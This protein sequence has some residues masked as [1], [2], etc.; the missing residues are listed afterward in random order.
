MDTLHKVNEARPIARCIASQIR[1]PLFCTLILAAFT[2]QAQQPDAMDAAAEEADSAFMEE[3]IVTGLRRTLESAQ[4]IKFQS[5]TIVDSIVADDIANLPDRSVTETLQRIPGVTIDRFISRGDP[6]HFGGEGS[7][8]AVRGLTQVRGEING[9][10]GFTANGGR[11]LSFED[12]PPELL[13]G[14]DVYKNATADMIEGGLG[15]TV[16]L[17]TRMPLDIDGRLFA[18]TATANN[19]NFIEET[20]PSFSAMYSNRWDT[21]AGEFGFLVDLAYSELKGRIDVLFSRPYFPRSDSIGSGD[22]GIPGTTGTVW[23]PRG[24]DWRTERTDRERQGVY[25]AF[26]WR[27]NNGM[28]YYA[29]VFR[30]EYDFTWD[31]DALFVDNDPYGIFPTSSPAGADSGDWAFDGAS[32][33]QS[34]TLSGWRFDDTNGDGVN[35]TWNEIGIPMGSDVRISNRNS[36]TTDFSQGF[37]WNINDNWRFTTDLQYVKATTDGLD[38]TIG[39]GITVP[40]MFVDMTGG[41]PQISTDT[42]YLSDPD[43]Y[44]IGFT[45]DHQDDNEA[46]QWAWRADLEYAFDDSALKAVKFG[47]RWAN[48][49]QTLINTGYNWVPVIQPWM[50]WWA[51]SGTDPLP[52]IADLG[53]GNVTT[54]NTFANF[55]RG[56]MPIPGAVVALTPAMAMGYPG[57]Y[58]D[59]HNGALPY[60]TCCYYSEQDGVRVTNFAPTLIQ[61]FHRNPQEQTVT[62][63]YLMAYFGWDNGLDG[64]VGVRFVETENTAGGYVIYP[65]TGSFPVEIQQAFPTEPLYQNAKNSYNDTLPSLNLRYRFTEQI[66]G[67]FSYSKAIFRPNFSDMQA[68]IQ[69]YLNLNAGAPNGSTNLNDYNGSASGGN[70][71]LEPMEA[72]QYD[73]SLEWYY[74]DV[75]SAWLNLFRKDIDGFIRSGRY[76][77]EY[78]GF[79]YL[80]QAPAN[81]DKAKLDG[82]ELGW[83]H[84]WDFG[85]GIEASYTYIDSSTNVTEQTIPVDTDGTSYN[86]ASL[87]YEGLSE[88]SYSTIFM[89]ENERVSARLAY[90]WRDEFLV[91]IG[92]NGFNGNNQNVQWQIPVFQEDYGQWDGSVF[93]NINENLA[94]GFEANNLTNEEI[95][96]S[97]RQLNSPGGKTFSVQDSRYALTLRVNY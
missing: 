93:Y 55:F 11:S 84:F 74:A 54:V 18:F 89:F 70:P 26:Q 51:L 14:V 6:E 30:S 65:N 77:R 23:A 34:G 88:N 67:R 80:I 85:F 9:R 59:I 94:I 29:S 82:W 75:G 8:V 4:N 15:G 40:E 91:S 81:Q 47:V 35:D 44:F 63:A 41:R 95:V 21:G 10:D 48:R 20:T 12:V 76:T 36:V 28:E 37:V 69:L 57:T 87:P 58:Y 25:A 42:D 60:Y 72:D 92:P 32:I 86:P 31:E 66:I 17:R 5:E 45:M 97:G 43:N 13:A 7:G 68:Y 38:S 52:T 39:A 3:V 2:L 22:Y 19:Q 78:A 71:W 73:L 79:P 27:S 1:W 64:N 61:D 53:L 62:S 50:Q 96:L 49:D 16:N 90:T 46:E 83:R 24:A 56:D 33:F